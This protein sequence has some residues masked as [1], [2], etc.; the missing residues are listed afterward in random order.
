M[1]GLRITMMSTAGCQH[2][3]APEFVSWLGLANPGGR[4]VYAV[5]F[6]SV[7]VHKAD[8]NKDPD[9]PKLEAVQKAT[10]KAHER[11]NVHLVQRRLGPHSFEYRA[12]KAR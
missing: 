12:V 8:L 4:I 9:A 2:I 6:L 3:T 7:A 11:G 1:C 5:G 10:W